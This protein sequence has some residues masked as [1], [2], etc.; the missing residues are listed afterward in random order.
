MGPSIK[1]YYVPILDRYGGNRY[2]DSPHTIYFF[3]PIHILMN[4]RVINFLP[5]SNVET[6]SSSIKFLE[7]KRPLFVLQLLHEIVAAHSVE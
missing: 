1:Y 3:R 6:I 7:Y 2:Y 5:M 4:Q